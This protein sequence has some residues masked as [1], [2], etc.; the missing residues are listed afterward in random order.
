[1]KSF[2]LLFLATGF[3]Y[4]QAEAQKPSR[5][6]PGKVKY[7]KTEQDATIFDIPYPAD[8]VED[9][10]KELAAQRGVKVKEKNGF[11]EARNLA[12]DKLGGKKHDVYYKVDK[13]GKGSSKV[14]MII[15][16]PGEDLA[17]RTSSHAVLAGTAAGGAVILASIVPHLDEHDFNTLKLAQEEEIKKAEKKLASLQDEQ[18]KLQKK[19][20]DIN[21]EIDK[22]ATDQNNATSELEAKKAA[23]AKFLEKR[24]GGKKKG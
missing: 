20:S 3:A 2:F 7:Q 4:L 22:N 10:L 11:Y 6:Y 1:M 14:S 13:A 18:S 8:Q 5:Q 9:G 19:L 24:E 12:M 23:L 16:E 21:K 17:N 15:A